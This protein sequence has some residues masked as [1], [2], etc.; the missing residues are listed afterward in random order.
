MCAGEYMA[1]RED[2]ERMAATLDATVRRSLRE[3]AAVGADPLQQEGAVAAA[4]AAARGA[5][6]RA[7]SEAADGAADADAPYFMVVGFEVAP[8]SV[9]RAPG[10]KIEAVTCAMG[11]AEGVPAQE[12]A[13]G[14]A[15]IYT[16]DVYWQVWGLRG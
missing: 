3:H 11:T 12:I 5:T 7:L 4:A 10:A 9:R 2:G 16:Y 13:E 6:R 1:A 8:C 15:I 14:A